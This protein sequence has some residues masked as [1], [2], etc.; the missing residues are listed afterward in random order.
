MGWEQ[1][2]GISIP[3]AEAEFLRTPR[4]SIDLIAT[5]LEAQ[6]EP[7]RACLT[8]RA[9]HRLRRSITGVTYVRREQVRAR[10]LL[11]ELV[12]TGSRRSWKAIR[13]ACG[14]PSLPGPGW[15]FPRTVGDL[16][17]WTVAY[18]AKDLK[19]PGEPWTRS[20]IRT[21]VRAVVTEVVGSEEFEDD[22]D[23]VHDIGIG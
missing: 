7:G 8:L 20:E 16:V 4:Q 1:S 18:A 15:F 14:I 3:D 13:F 5:K 6:D 10:A 11:R 2:F 19:R 9:F 17:R 21:V 23:F 12:R 22:D